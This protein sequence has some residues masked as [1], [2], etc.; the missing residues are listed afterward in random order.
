M[1]MLG[2]ANDKI[3]RL[4][5]EAQHSLHFFFRIKP[6]EDLHFPLF[7]L[8]DHDFHS[9]IEL[10]LHKFA[11]N[12][13]LDPPQ[14]HHGNALMYTHSILVSVALNEVSQQDLTKLCALPLLGH[15]GRYLQSASLR[16]WLTPSS[17]LCIHVAKL[18]AGDLNGL[19]R[20]YLKQNNLEHLFY[21]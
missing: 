16:R 15:L 9:G 7:L 8:L 5:G 18:L 11:E 10:V 4:L 19:S 20:R 3:A 2:W 12:T 6:T 17:E 13:Q 21:N 1:T 14:T